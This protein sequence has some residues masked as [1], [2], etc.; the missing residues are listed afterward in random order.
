MPRTPRPSAPRSHWPRPWLPVLAPARGPA[1]IASYL[2]FHL[3]GAAVGRSMLDRCMSA[4][5]PDDAVR[6]LPLRAQFEDEI[7]VARQLLARLTVVGTPGRGLV[8][9]SSGVALSVLPAGPTLLD[10]LT[11]LGLLEALRTVVVAKRS[12]WELLA[13][14]WVA[15]GSADGNDDPTA[16]D[17]LLGLSD[18]AASQERL[19][20]SLRR[21]Y[22][23]AAFR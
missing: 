6:L 1:A 8:R 4:V 11:R 10:P 18:Q 19:L 9:L 17:I 5:G 21:T 2:R 22:G 3:Y 7:D 23:L 16:R 12:M 13:D 14:S 20:D 15:D